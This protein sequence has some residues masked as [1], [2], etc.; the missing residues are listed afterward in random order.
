MKNK[1]NET[2][3]L[4][5]KYR[6]RE[7]EKRKRRIHTI[8]IKS[9]IPSIYGGKLHSNLNLDVKSNLQGKNKKVKKS[10]F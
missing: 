3:R 8:K 1:E 10:S 9:V 5:I 4:L 6:E 2:E 7:R